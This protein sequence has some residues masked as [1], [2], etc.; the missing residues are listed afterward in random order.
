MIGKVKKWLGIEGVKLELILPDT[1]Q[2]DANV[3]RGRISFTSLHE[4][5]VESFRIVLIEKYQ[6]GRKEEK[7]ID[8]YELGQYN[9]E[10]EIIIPAEGTIELKFELPFTITDSE[11]D[12]IGNK[13]VLTGAFVKA[14]KY[15]EGVKSEFRVE[16]EAKVSGVALNPFDKK[17]IELV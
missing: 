11:M 17:S 16:A 12:T 13:N 9:E 8:E 14:L 7:L 2:K 3:L 15:Y 4:Q 1:I 5:R 6:R 10:K